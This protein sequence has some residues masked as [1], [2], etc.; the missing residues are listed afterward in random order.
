MISQWGIFTSEKQVARAIRKKAAQNRVKKGEGQSGGWFSPIN[1]F[2]STLSM[3]SPRGIS[4]MLYWRATKGNPSQRVYKKLYTI[5]L[6]KG[7]ANLVD[8]FPPSMVSSP[9]YQWFPLGE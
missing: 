4:S 6:R 1:G 2:F 8:G 7:R 9:P 5:G 3:V